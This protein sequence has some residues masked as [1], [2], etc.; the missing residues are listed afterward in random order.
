MQHSVG[1]LNLPCVVYLTLKHTF[2]NYFNTKKTLTS[3]GASDI[4]T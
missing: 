4:T 1:A 3:L 2:T